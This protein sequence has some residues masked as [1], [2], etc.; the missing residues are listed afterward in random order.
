VKKVTDNKV[1]PNQVWKNGTTCFKVVRTTPSTI[2]G[3]LRNGIKG[4]YEST[5][6]KIKRNELRADYALA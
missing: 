2:F 4:R 6:S 5:V 1:A 3:V